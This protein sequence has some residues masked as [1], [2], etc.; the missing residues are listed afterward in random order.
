MLGTAAGMSLAQSLTLGFMLLTKTVHPPV[1]ANSLIMVYGHSGFAVLWQPVLVGVLS[2]ALVAFVWTR[3]LPGLV[4]YR[5]V[6]LD[7]SPPS[8]LWG[9]PGRIAIAHLTPA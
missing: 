5:V 6:W 2:L 4:R 9:W 3:A 8:T 1:G 7:A